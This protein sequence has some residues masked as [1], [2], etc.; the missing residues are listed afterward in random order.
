MAIRTMPPQ[1]FLRECFDY[2]PDTGVTIWRARPRAH[3]VSTGAWKRWNTLYPSKRADSTAHKFGHRQICLMDQN[4]LA[5]RLIWKWMTGEDPIEVDHRKD[6][7]DNRW[8]NLRHS[9]RSGNNRNRRKIPNTISGFKGVYPV[10]KSHRFGAHIRVDGI[11]IRLGSFA[12]K[13]E[14]HAA[15]CAAAKEHFGEFWNPG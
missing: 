1:Q 10:S 6:A 14:A 7:G 9:S 4:W 8:G 3:F 11:M 5:H 13:A 2:N 12:T 15:Y